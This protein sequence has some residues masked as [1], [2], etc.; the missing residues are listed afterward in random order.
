MA[1]RAKQIVPL[2]DRILVQRIK[3]EQ[4]TASG[5]LIPEKAQEA[6]N[7]GRV[8]AT[9]KGA[10]D[11]DGKLIPMSVKEGDKVLLPP[12]GG[13]PVKVDKE[14]YLLFRDSEILAKIEE[15]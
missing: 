15:A 7:E 9:G 12:Y 6:L 1:S 13:N 14:E 5:I 11:K 4:R 8:V 3:P 10:L 2:L